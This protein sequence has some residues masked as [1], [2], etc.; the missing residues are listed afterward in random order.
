[1]LYACSAV[2]R[3]PQDI[4]LHQLAKSPTPR[5]HRHTGRGRYP[6]WEQQQSLA[7]ALHNVSALFHALQVSG[8]AGPVAT[9]DLV[10]LRS[11]NPVL[12]SC[13]SKPGKGQIW[14]GYGANVSTAFTLEKVG[15][16]AVGT[17]ID[18]NTDKLFLKAG[19]QYCRWIADLSL[20]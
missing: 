7:L 4:S 18:F 5:T 1:M 9:G 20:S 17:V 15:S 14:C 3:Q 11:F 6:R 13:I 16:S 2:L 10:N 19:G 8:V 12:S